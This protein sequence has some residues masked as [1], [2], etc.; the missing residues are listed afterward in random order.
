MDVVLDNHNS[1]SV[2]PCHLFSTVPN[3]R[4][5]MKARQE[6]SLLFKQ[7]GHFISNQWTCSIV[8]KGIQN[9]I[10]SL[11]VLD[12]TSSSLRFSEILEVIVRLVSAMLV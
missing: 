6:F 11:F 12:S 3:N 4:I 1:V 2:S 10:N 5:F 7:I 8:N 9:A